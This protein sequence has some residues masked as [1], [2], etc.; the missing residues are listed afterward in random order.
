[1]PNCKDEVAEA[2]YLYYIGAITV[3]EKRRRIYVAKFKN[4]YKEQ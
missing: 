3:E 1:M 2:E 4:I